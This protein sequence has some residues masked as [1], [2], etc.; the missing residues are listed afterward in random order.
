M[1]DQAALDLLVEQR[2][3]VLGTLS[4][5]GAP[6]VCTIFYVLAP[7]RSIVFKSRFASE[8]TQAALRDGR[9]ALAVY[10]HDS[11]YDIKVG[12]QVLGEIVPIR[13][14]GEMRQEVDRY[15]ERFEGSAT[16][17][18]PI[19]ELVRSD[20]FSTLYRFNPTH[21]K[22]MDLRVPRVDQTYVTFGNT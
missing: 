8:H 18:A 20:A 15:S 14:E 19:D 2:V 12:V 11:T 16:K 7:D 13:D 21:Y 10:R 6:R 22:V 4:E 3:G 9:A 17:F 1:F 5:D